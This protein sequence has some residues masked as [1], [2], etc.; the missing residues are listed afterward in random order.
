MGNG[1]KVGGNPFSNMTYEKIFSL[2]TQTTEISSYYTYLG[3]GKM[4]ENVL[5]G[6]EGV[7]W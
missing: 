7:E 2:L 4:P 3:L 6:F 1:W 5:R